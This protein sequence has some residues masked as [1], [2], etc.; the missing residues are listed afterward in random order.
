MHS[1]SNL[2]HHIEYSLRDPRCSPNETK[3]FIISKISN[4]NDA[5]IN[6]N[7]YDDNNNYNQAQTHSQ[8]HPMH[9]NFTVRFI[10]YLCDFTDLQYLH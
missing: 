5:A 9:F 4:D 7:I 8:F 10:I 6:N 1:S 3:Q 2:L